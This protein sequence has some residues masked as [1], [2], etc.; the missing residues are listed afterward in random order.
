MNAV[1]STKLTSADRFAKDI[2]K[3]F[4]KYYRDCVSERIKEGI[5]LK[6][7]KMASTNG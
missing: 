5:A 2:K 3:I 4:K 1:K 7:I 6:K